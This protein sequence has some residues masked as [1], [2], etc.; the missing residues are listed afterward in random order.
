MHLG[1]RQAAVAGNGFDD[2]LA[3]L[4]IDAQAQLVE[5]AAGD[6]FRGIAG[7]TAKAVV[8]FQEAPFAPFQQADGVGTGM[9]GLGELFLAGL[10]R[11]GGLLQA[12]DV[13]ERGGEVAVALHRQI[14]AGDQAGD[15]PAILAA[16]AGQGAV[17]HLLA[18]QFLDHF[19]TSL[20]VLPE[21]DLPGGPADQLGGLPAENLAEAGVDIDEATAL[22]LG[23]RNGYRAALEQGR[24]L[25][26]RGAQTLFVEH[27]AGHVVEDAGHAQ[28][29]ALG[30]AVQPRGA[31]QVVDFA[32]GHACAVA[33]AAFAVTAGQQRAIGLAQAFPVLLV[34]SAEEGAEIAAGVGQRQAVHG[35]GARRALQAVAGNVPLPGAQVGRF[36]GQCQAFA[37]VAQGLFLGAQLRDVAHRGDHA[38][39]AMQLDGGAKE[40]EGADAAVAPAQARLVVAQA[41]VAGEL[42]EHPFAF[43]DVDPQVQL[44]RGAADGQ[45]LAPAKR[46]DEALVD[47]D[48]SPRLQITDG[49]GVG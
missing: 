10:Q 28:G 33:Q 29:V 6:F 16:E 35:E 39:T 3:L 7:E 44:V 5:A 45:F 8:D 27:S 2:L 14:A 4:G 48:E 47:L 20:V 23:H 40:T 46:V 42:L 11:A 31:F 9:E 26:F 32:A 37:A 24:E 38:G 13:V 25:L 34:H 22:R 21:A 12:G 15:A 19:G 1:A 17:Q 49:D 18:V 41:A 43:L 36:Q 30:V